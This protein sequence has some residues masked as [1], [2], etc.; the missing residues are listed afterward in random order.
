MAEPTAPPTPPP[1]GWGA[2]QLTSY[3]EQARL[4]GWATYT[5][6]DTREWYKRL[7]AIDALYPQCIDA[8]Q[9]RTPHRVESLMLICTHGAWRAAAEFAMQG[10][11]CETMV[12]LRSAL[13]YALYAAH[14]QRHP[15]L[16][17][18]WMHRSDGL[19]QLQA[20][21]KN[22]RPS[23]MLDELQTTHDAIGSRARLLYDRMIDTGAHPNEVAFFGRLGIADAPT[24]GGHEVKVQYFQGGDTAQ[25]HA[26]KTVCQV[27]V[28]A[29]ECFR[30]IWPERF[31]IV[32]ITD[33]MQKLMPDL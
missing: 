13:E 23:A 2:D 28:C 32:G 25:Q 1:P 11:S 27:G 7:V 26:L 33:A 16:V 10:R 19:E 29:L 30:L 17:K 22:F 6:P 8:L 18:V 15:E 3:F 31:D 9:A 14:F 12:L 4:S 20:V 21:K 24:E 5:Q